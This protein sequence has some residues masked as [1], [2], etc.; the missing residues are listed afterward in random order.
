M[1]FLAFSAADDRVRSWGNIV[2]I[3]EQM[4]YLAVFAAA[5]AVALL[6]RGFDLSLGNTV[7]LVSVSF[8]LVAT[9]VWPG[10]PSGIL[11]FLGI[12]A[13]LGAALLVGLFNGYIVAYLGVS[14]FVV[15]LGSLNICLGL[16]SMLSNGYPVGGIPANFEMV[17][18]SGRLAGVPAPIIWASALLVLLHGVLNY[19]TVGRSW[20]LLGDNPRAA[21]LAGIATK[22][23]VLW[24]FLTASLLAAVGALMV[25]ARTGSG[26]PNLGGDLTLRSAAAAAIGGVSLRGGIGGV[27]EVLLGTL[28]VTVL[29]NGMNFTQ[30]NGYLQQIVL[31]IVIIFAVSL[32]R[33]RT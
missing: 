22:R 10:L 18:Y 27:G 28:L 13:A 2:N 14:T 15:T 4:S 25:T 30:V 12:L 33:K 6:V 24:A 3:A 32:D 7:S 5:Q 19:T 31:G 11:L 16:A 26:E 9:A 23:L 8:A 1:L 21:V 20:Y 17:L 29:S